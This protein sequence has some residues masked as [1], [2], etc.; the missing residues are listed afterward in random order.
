MISEPT[1]T[2]IQLRSRTTGLL[3]YIKKFNYR[4]YEQWTDIELDSLKEMKELKF[5]RQQIAYAL[6]RSMIA[7]SEIKDTQLYK[8]KRKAYGPQKWTSEIDN[9]IIKMYN[10]NPNYS[11]ISEFVNHNFFETRPSII[12]G[13]ITKLRKE[14][15][16]LVNKATKLSKIFND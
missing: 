16:F 14:N 13:R 3:H 12:A 4:H 10:E 9:A 15:P 1:F 6:G 11:I 2:F 8:E 7:V 5:N